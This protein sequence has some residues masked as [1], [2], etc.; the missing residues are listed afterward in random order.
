MDLWLGETTLSA[1]L[2]FLMASAVLPKKCV[3][4]ET[5]RRVIMRGGHS[6]EN[7]NQ[8]ESC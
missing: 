5:G 8:T 3:I 2:P 1:V 7:L 4:S 6:F